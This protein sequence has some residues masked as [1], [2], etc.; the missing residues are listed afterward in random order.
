MKDRTDKMRSLAFF[1]ACLLVPFL[2]CRLGQAEDVSYRIRVP[3]PV[4]DSSAKS[5]QTDLRALGERLKEA[6]GNATVVFEL[7]TSGNVTGEGS[8]FEAAFGI[9]R[10]IQS[11]EWA[12]VRKIA[13]VP[14]PAGFSAK[15]IQ[16]LNVK[17][18]SELS[19]HALLVALACDQLWMDEESFLGVV[20]SEDDVELLAPNY[21]TIARRGLQWPEALVNV[22]VD[23]RQGLYRVTKTD[24][25]KVLVGREARNALGDAGDEVASDEW[26]P[27]GPVV[28]WSAQKLE[29]WG[30]I[31]PP[32]LG[33]DD[34]LNRVPGKRL[35]NLSIGSVKDDWVARKLEVTHLDSSFISWSTRGINSEI[36]VDGANLLFISINTLGAS[37]FQ[38]AADF[39]ELLL[40]LD[41]DS[42]RLVALLP[43]GASGPETLV[44]LSCD[45]IIIAEDKRIGGGQV[46]PLEDEA[47]LQRLDGICRSIATVTGRD[48]SLVAGMALDNVEVREFR[49]RD[50]G[51]QRLLTEEQWNELPDKAT[52]QKQQIVPLGN[53]LTAE[54]AESRGVVQHIV[55]DMSTVREFYNVEQWKE[56]R[57]TVT[58]RGIQR[59]ADFIVSP[60]VSSLLLFVGMFALFSELSAPGLGLPGF[61]SACCLTLFFWAHYAEGNADILE[62]VLFVL[63]VLFVLLELF[64]IPGFGIF[65]LGGALMILASIVLASQ[66]FVIPRSNAQVNTLAVNVLTLLSGMAGVFASILFMRYYLDRMPFFNHLVLEPPQQRQEIGE[67]VE[68]ANELSS[69][70]NH[71]GVAL[72]M[73]RPSGKAKFGNR[74]VNVITDGRMIEKDETVRV[75]E[76]SG[77]V[78]KV[79]LKET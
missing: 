63:G 43:E 8:S 6:E 23:N 36:L 32:V 76:I 56:V 34:L 13:Y 59:F 35:V 22:L 57:P 65:G 75:Y 10:T 17:S 16:N 53:G 71:T 73:L 31:E 78:V 21:T 9:A 49:N 14:P 18:R 29:S 55:R 15:A 45:E 46:L 28:G 1:F 38:S 37:D 51:G 30:V 11:T 61:L 77:S 72:T 60:P 79:E 7:D 25:S 52:W 3:L 64:V 62:I 4:N 48:W 42:V 69:L 70:L 33:R 39:S 5:V 50:T 58:D 2:V 54:E 74:V 24:G 66:D 47:L 44:A 40:G 20:G 26:V 12:S 67:T 27:P 19:G 68:G 41:R